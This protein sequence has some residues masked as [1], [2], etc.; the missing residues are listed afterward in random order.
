MKNLRTL[1]EVRAFVRAHDPFTLP[2]F[3]ELVATRDACREPQEPLM[4]FRRFILHGRRPVSTL[5]WE[6]G[7]KWSTTF[8]AELEKLAPDNDVMLADPIA[9]LLPWMIATFL[10][11]VEDRCP[12]CQEGW[13]VRNLHDM[14]Q[15]RVDEKWAPVHKSCK[16]FEWDL[17]NLADY[18]TLLDA[19]GFSKYYLV[20]EPSNYHRDFGA[21]AT[22]KLPRDKTLHIGWRKRVIEIRWDGATADPS[23]MADRLFPNETCT[24]EGFMIH[25]WNDACAAE[26]LETIRVALG[27]RKADKGS[28]HKEPKQ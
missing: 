8:L 16:K 17:A 28:K 7:S 5:L 26:Y 11:A 15:I 23:L 25:A 2:D 12:H 4:L 3:L 20:P 21:I 22:V 1:A 14:A 10:P 27:I 6:D 24:K 13:N 9:A 19:A 18:T